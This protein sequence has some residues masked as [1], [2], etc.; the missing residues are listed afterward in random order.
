MV[1]GVKPSL[2]ELYICTTLHIHFLLAHIE[3]V[4]SRGDCS[5]FFGDLGLC[6]YKVRA[7]EIAKC[8]DVQAFANHQK[9]FR[10]L[11][12]RCNWRCAGGLPTHLRQSRAQGWRIFLQMGCP[13]VTA[14]VHAYVGVPRIVLGDLPT[15]QNMKK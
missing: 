9:R 7:Q 11:D 8:S 2:V 3:T 5:E 14:T 12:R 4:L 1:G 13:E 15:S 10:E 6:L